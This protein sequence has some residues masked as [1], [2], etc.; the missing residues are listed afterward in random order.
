MVVDDRQ[1]AV[2]GMVWDNHPVGKG[3]KQDPTNKHNRE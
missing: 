1:P 2:L 3:T